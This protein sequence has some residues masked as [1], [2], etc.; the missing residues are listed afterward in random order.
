MFL[1]G[2]RPGTESQQYIVNF[3]CY[4]G[5]YKFIVVLTKLFLVFKAMRLQL[6]IR[7][8][9]HSI[10]CLMTHFVK[11][12]NIK[13]I[14]FWKKQY[15]FK[16]ILGQFLPPLLFFSAMLNLSPSPLTPLCALV[17]LLCLSSWLD[18]NVSGRLGQTVTAAAE[19]AAV[20]R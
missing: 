1:T 8:I 2:H 15:H 14:A 3:L 10:S 18:W 12:K 13:N 20:N 16:V 9:V 17:N 4:S 5:P 6:K 19:A 7:S 11:L